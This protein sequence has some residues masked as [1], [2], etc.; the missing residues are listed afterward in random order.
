MLFFPETIR[1][2]PLMDKKQAIVVGLM[3]NEISVHLFNILI[4]PVHDEANGIETSPILSD[5]TLFRKK[6][7]FE[8][9]KQPLLPYDLSFIAKAEIEAL[10]VDI[11]SI[12]AFQ[13]WFDHVL[14]LKL[15]SQDALPV[16]LYLDVATA[17]DG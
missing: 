9:E 7:C 5:L 14:L 11:A 17:L 13:F 6:L 8:D 15:F 2:V 16:I 12:F 4:K 10:V 1:I 3:L